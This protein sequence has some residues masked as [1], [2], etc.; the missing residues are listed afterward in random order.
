MGAYISYHIILE[1]IPVFVK[2]Q[3]YGKDQCKID[4]I[5]IPEPI[6]VISAAV[7]LIVM[8]LFIPF[9]VYEW[10]QLE[11]SIPHQKFSMFL[12]ALTAICSAVLLGFADDV[13]DLRWRHKLLFPTLS[14]LPLLLVYYVSGSSATIVLP[15][16]VRV[17]FPVSECIDIGI[18]YY[19]YMGM[20]IV[21]CTNAINILAGINGLEAGQAFIIAASVVIFNAVELFR[22]DQSLSWYHSLSLYF[23]L[24]FLG[25]TSVLLY[26]NWYP[27]RIFVGDTFCYWA[28]M[29]LASAC[30]LGHFS[31][32]MALFLIP[33]IF[34]FIYSI[35]QLFHLIP[36][37]RH[38][39]PKYDS[40]SD[41]VDMST[42]E[43]KENDL[44]PLTKIVLYF[45]DTF[46]LLYKEIIEKDDVKWIVI[47]NLTLLNL[48]LKFT[49]PVHEK[50]LTEMLLMLQVLF[51]VLAFFIRFYVAHLMY[52][53][54]L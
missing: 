24:P 33:Q 40:K 14:S 22:L 3:M 44:I 27:A 42:V 53:V 48:V 47:N 1:Y 4:N 31:K 9:S 5:P 28:G 11:S 29:T 32:T 41:T 13:L 12:S 25:T 7:Y 21:F 20:M 34:N 49:G 50:K 23:L 30:I 52:E 15:S 46:S 2:R 10:S 6:G 37:P 16:L 36:C 54:V 18:F 19:I 26:F 38:R 51:S 45:L 43:F 8:F 35:P 39:L 17:L